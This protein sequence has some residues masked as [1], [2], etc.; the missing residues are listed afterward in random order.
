MEKFILRDRTL[1]HQF[2]ELHPKYLKKYCEGELSGPRN[3][4]IVQFLTEA[5]P[6]HEQ[7][8]EKCLERQEK[9]QYRSKLSCIDWPS[10]STTAASTCK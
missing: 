9:D 10:S 3:D 1:N 7:I 5:P 2:D 6:S 8:L 4:P